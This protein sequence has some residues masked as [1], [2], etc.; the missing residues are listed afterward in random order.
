MFT[1]V[2]QSGVLKK[3]DLP[4]ASLLGR[5]PP[6]RLVEFQAEAVRLSER[7]RQAGE[8]LSYSDSWACDLTLINQELAALAVEKRWAGTPSY[9]GVRDSSQA[10]RFRVQRCRAED[11]NDAFHDRLK[12]WA[13]D[14]SLHAYFSRISG[15]SKMT[16]ATLKPSGWWPSHFD[17]NSGHGVKVNLVLSSN[18]DCRTLIWN[19]RAG[20]LE[21]VNMQPGEVWYLN[22]GMRHA[23]HNWGSSDRTHL[24]MTFRSPEVLSHENFD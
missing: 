10:R 12:P 20:R 21:R 5:I 2:E 1:S 13:Q 24:L 22:V 4:E 23:A 15:L 14:S 6:G 3:Y 17:F 18:P 9:R 8:L 16:L 7:A 19:G 11:M